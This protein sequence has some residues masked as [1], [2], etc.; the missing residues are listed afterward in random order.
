M[1]QIGRY[2]VLEEIAR[3]GMGVVY[4]ALDPVS[5]RKVAIKVLLSPDPDPRFLQEIRSLAIAGT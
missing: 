5:K 1:K 2:E 4:K 3:G